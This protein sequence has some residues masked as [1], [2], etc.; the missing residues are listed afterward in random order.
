MDPKED[1]FEKAGKSLFSLVKTI[2]LMLWRFSQAHKQKVQPCF[3][4]RYSNTNPWTAYDDIP[5]RSTE[6]VP[7]E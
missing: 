6:V 1:C 5:H 4:E 3:R 2:A 7:K